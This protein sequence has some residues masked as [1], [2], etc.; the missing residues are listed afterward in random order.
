[1][2]SLFRRSVTAFAKATMTDETE[3]ELTKIAHEILGDRKLMGSNVEPRVLEAFAVGI[4]FAMSKIDE[5]EQLYMFLGN[6]YLLLA[7]HN[8]DDRMTMQVDESSKDLT[9]KSK[10]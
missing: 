2:S 4:E 7:K 5:R 8:I 9:N 10:K 6:V 1:M 3:K